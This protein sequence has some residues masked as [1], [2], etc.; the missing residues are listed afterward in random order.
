M[1]H[2]IP[3]YAVC[4][5]CSVEPSPLGGYGLFYT[6]T[7]AP[8]SSD[9]ELL[10]IPSQSVLNLGNLLKALN[11]LKS[12][13]RH[14]P[15]IDVHESKTIIGILQALSPI[16]ET[17][18][19][20]AYILAFKVLILAGDKSQY[21]QSSP[22]RKFDDY[23]EVLSTTQVLDPAV[24]PEFTQ[25]IREEYEHFTSEWDSS[26]KHLLTFEIFYQL[27]QAVRSRVLE[28]PRGIDGSS[29]DF[30]TDVSL[31]PVLDFANHRSSGSHNAVFDVDRQTN[32][33]VLRLLQVDES[34]K[35][36]VTICYD[37]E[38][39]TDDFFFTYGFNPQ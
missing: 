37:V 14:F 26:E 25:S 2:I 11:E 13:D 35:F 15:Q 8:P 17:T 10:R 39:K 31:V 30:T 3:T 4:T 9:L 27:L 38:D 16:S 29:E 28:I 19:I 5:S 24:S 23:I 1:S 7:N 20:F 32:D 36:E 12:R 21:F 6:P 33:V 18:V 34:S 22:L